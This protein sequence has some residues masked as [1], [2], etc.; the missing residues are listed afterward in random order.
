MKKPLKPIF[1]RFNV[2]L[3]RAIVYVSVAEKIQDARD[4]MKYLFGY[5]DTVG[6][7]ALYSNAAI[8]QIHAL[9]FMFCNLTPQTI[10]HEIT[11]LKNGIFN[12]AG[13]KPETGNDEAECYLVDYLTERVYGIVKP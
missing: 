8:G 2:P 5:Y 11:H 1:K 4:R 3:Y 12:K 10:A 7:G 13:Y 6:D 9:S